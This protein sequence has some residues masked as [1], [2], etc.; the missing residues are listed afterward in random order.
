MPLPRTVEVLRH[1]TLPGGRP[2][3]V[4]V[5]GALVGSVV[6]AG[7]APA[8]LDGLDLTGFVL[9]TAPAEPHAHL[10]KAG[11]WDAI[12]PPVGDLT[13]AIESW[14]RFAATTT[15]AEIADRAR[16]QLT[17][18]LRNGTTAVRSHVD[19]LLDGDPLRA[20]RA[21]VEVRA[22][23]AG[24]MDV[25]LVALASEFV[26]DAVYRDAIALGVDLIGGAPHLAADPA[27]Q[28]GRQIALA[29][30]LGVGIDLH[31]DESLHGPVTILDFAHAV[32]GWTVPVTA[33]HCVRLGTMPPAELATVLDAVAAGPMGLVTLPIT[34]LYLQGWAD[35][36]ATPRGLTALRA[37]LEAGIPLGAGADNVRDP[38]NP[39]GRSDALETASLLVTA[40]HLTLDE[41]LHLI[42][43]GARRVMGMTAAGAQPG[44]QADFLAVR[45]T[46]AGEIVAEAGPDR[47]VIHRGR[48]VSAS[49]VHHDTA[50][51]LIAH[52]PA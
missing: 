13:R 32:A 39:V 45:G 18:H 23:F 17:R 29:A 50:L 3:D 35:L 33:G 28:L 15:R 40:G 44:A 41:A 37:I 19:L 27:G 31:T 30:E 49:R 24:L 16:A 42:T 46:G 12:R 48:L 2:V 26:D 25:Q 20:V 4:V 43:D 21:L 22:E 51:P 5:D 38:F 34:N 11:S 10:D 9:L 6:D 52:E 8:R 14:V 36:V 47:F 1:A 7:T